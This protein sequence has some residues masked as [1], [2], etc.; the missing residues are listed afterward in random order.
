MVDTDSPPADTASA[1]KS[2]QLGTEDSG[3]YDLLRTA[4]HAEGA[5]APNSSSRD[6]PVVLPSTRDGLCVQLELYTFSEEDGVSCISSSCSPSLLTKRADGKALD[7][8]GM[9]GAEGSKVLYPLCSAC[10]ESAIAEMEPACAHER[11]LIRKYERALKRLERSLQVRR[12]DVYSSSFD[13]ASTMAE[14]QKLEEE[15]KQLE[16]EIISLEAST[17][18]KEEQQRAVMAELVELHMWHVEFWLLFSNH[19]LRMIRH[20]ERKR[21]MERLF[22][23]VGR[24]L[25]RLKRINVVNDAFHIWT[26]KFLPSIN[27]CRIGRISSPSC[28]SWSEVNTGWGYLCMLLDVFYRKCHT[29]PSNYR[30]V[31]RGQ[32]SFLIRKKDGAVLPLHGGGGEVG[33]SRFFYSNKRFDSA[34]TAF[35]ECVKELFDQLVTSAEGRGRQQGVASLLPFPELPYEIDG[36]RVGGF[37]IRLQLNQ[38]ERWTKALKL[39][40]IDMKWLLEYIERVCLVAGS[41]P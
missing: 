23:Y 11:Y 21:A 6:A 12:D 39:L 5:Y 37:S 29:Q 18:E 4:V 34:M 26:C 14:L 28:P 38:D 7:V 24:E 3:Q 33:L 35:L 19:L 40:L 1:Q 41:A 22:V 27:K 31:A 8:S 20:E 13:S 16:A 25:Q 10:L 32:F 9:D 15:E 30:L 36:D 2:R 17:A